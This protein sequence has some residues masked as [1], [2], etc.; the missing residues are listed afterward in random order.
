MQ[1]C[2]LGSKVKGQRAAWAA[3][4]VLVTDKP[5]VSPLWAS[6]ST[7]FRGKVCARFCAF[8]VLRPAPRPGP[9]RAP[10][11][12]AAGLSV[13]RPRAGPP[14][15][16]YPQQAI[17]GFVGAITPAL[18]EVPISLWTKTRIYV[19]HHIIDSNAYI[20]RTATPNHTLQ[21]T[22]VVEVCG[23]ESSGSPL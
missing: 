14:M 20:H 8:R 2:A 1:R 5:E 12:A 10:S 7:Q 6:S 3:C 13:Q 15:H 17:Y 22:S 23:P 18:P 16:M 21:Q 11:P 4:A 9:V 19:T